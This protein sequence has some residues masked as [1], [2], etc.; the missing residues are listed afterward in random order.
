MSACDCCDPFPIDVVMMEGRKIGASLTKCGFNEFDEYGLNYVLPDTLGIVRTGPFL[1][2]KFFTQEA[3]TIEAEDGEEI[4]TQGT[5]TQTLTFNDETGEC[6]SDIVKTG[7]ANTSFDG[8][9]SVVSR[10]ISD[11]YTNTELID[12][13]LTQIPDE[14]SGE[15]S[16]LNNSASRYLDDSLYDGII[17]SNYSEERLQVRI[18]HP[19]TATGYL[20]VWML[21]RVRVL[22]TPLPVTYSE[23]TDT[24]FDVYE[25]EGEPPS[26][27]HGID[28]PENRIV[29]DPFLVPREETLTLQTV[30]D[31]LGTLNTAETIVEIVVY[32]WSLIEGYEPADPLTDEETL[33]LE[34]PSPDCESNGVPTLNEDCPFRE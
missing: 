1:S 17:E 4:G 13:T 26:L 19:P 15:W 9:I 20:K 11:E 23:P 29:S 8:N 21:K 18:S 12:N 24:P 34:R 10:T 22:E 28:E 31:E 32:K 14:F 33:E 2:T 6:D 16:T 30:T 5:W 3:I 25:W 7:L 27:E